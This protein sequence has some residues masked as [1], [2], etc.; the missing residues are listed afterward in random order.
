M[1]PID[2][3]EFRARWRA[4]YPGTVPLG[5]R[6]RL[7]HPQRWLRIHSLPAGERYAS[8]PADQATLLT[9]QNRAADLLLGEQTTVALLGYE[10]TGCYMLPDDHPLRRF[11][12]ADAPPILRLAPDDEHEE[13]ISVFGGLRAWRSG[14]LDY[15]LM[16]V[17]DDRFR[18]MLLRWDTGA[19]F[20]P[21]DG[22][23]DLFFPSPDDRERVRPLLEAWLSH[24]PEGL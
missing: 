16:G 18:L 19:G 23:V 4:W 21:Y 24:H 13:A 17:A 15:L 11:L 7:T 20:A 6:M 1:I 8:S 9:R 2:A 22:G 12:P 14:D 5:H 3:P 10:Y